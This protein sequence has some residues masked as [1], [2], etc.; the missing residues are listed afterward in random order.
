MAEPNGM[1]SMVSDVCTPGECL[2]HQLMK[3]FLFDLLDSSGFDPYVDGT[4]VVW[5]LFLL[6]QDVNV[7]VPRLDA[8][9]T[10][11]DSFQVCFLAQS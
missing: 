3:H 6:L 4:F 11:K 1:G 8:L 10:H 2:Y 9:A 5:R 7:N